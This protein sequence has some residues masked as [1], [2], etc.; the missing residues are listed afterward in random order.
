MNAR[1]QV[2]ARHPCFDER[3][4][5]QVGRVH[6]PVAPRCNIQCAFCERRL[7]ANL[8]MQHPGWAREVLRPAEALERVRCLV[9]EHER[10]PFVVGVAGPGEPLANEETFETLAAVHR[11]FPHLLTCLS[12]NGLLLQDSLPRLLDVGV[13]ALTVT[14][15][16]ADPQVA[17]QI[18]LWA[19]YQGRLYRGLE[20]ATLLIEKQFAGLC[21][22]LSADLAVKVNT[23][24][25]PDVNDGH[26]L[27]LAATLRDL[28]VPLM[29]LMPLLPAGRMAGRPPPTCDELR[30]AR[31]ACAAL[32]PQFRLCEHCRAD[33][34][35]FPD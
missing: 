32:L 10:Q 23:V 8:I 1:A 12:S 2:A 25:I 18:Y 3:A 17:A 6:L 11:E 30:N 26:V 22:A 34:I 16:A 21:A 19:R 9:R 24:F 27:D 4:H 13:Q 29:N 28:G 7:C 33:V 31:E 20:A 15:N 35:H 14:I 5:A